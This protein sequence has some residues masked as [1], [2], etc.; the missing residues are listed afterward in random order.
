MALLSCTPAEAGFS[1]EEP[2]AD[3][4]ETVRPGIAVLLADSIHL[5]A[6]HR[7]GLITNHTG[8]MTVSGVERSTVDLLHEHPRVNLVALYGPE[9]GLRGAAEAG[10]KVDDGV[11]DAT[12]LPVF[13]LYGS[14]LAPTAEMLEGVDALVFDIQDIGTRYYTYVWTMALS[15]QAAALADIPFVVLDRPNPIGG[16]LV[17]GNVLHP[18]FGSFVGLYPVP[19]RHGMTPAEM[20]LWVNDTQGF[21]ADLRIVPAEGWTRSSS[22]ED[23]GLPWRAPSPN[24]PSVVSALHYPGTCL[25]EGTNMSVGRGTDRAF[26]WV[27]APFLDGEL[28]AAELN[29]L[30]LP[31]TRF[32]AARFTP[33]DAGDGKFSGVEV[34][35]VR[36]IATD[37]AIYDPVRAAIATLSAAR[38]MA[39]GDWDWFETHFDRLAGTDQLRLA[40]ESEEPEV[41]TA[42]LDE[43]EAQ[44]A[45]FV[46][47]SGKYRIYP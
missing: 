15:M 1:A 27:G 24:M 8:F 16:E 43:W 37:P 9:H 46:A 2:Q 42:L 19:M 7:V 38:Y 26:E 11:D 40:I 47:E 6:G 41:L 44:A 23:T 32:E 39:G 18:D 21:G 35:G 34:E 33:Q 13:S 5:L 30:N 17:Q 31:G 25:F 28:L 29:G 10:E 45:A 3:V 12:G 20:A 14:T 22:W 36:F 4:Q